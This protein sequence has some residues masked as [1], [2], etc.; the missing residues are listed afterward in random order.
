ML[1]CAALSDCAAYQDLTRPTNHPHNGLVSH[2]TI[3]KIISG[4]FN[5]SGNIGG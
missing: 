3:A 1:D 2:S 4:F 5:Q